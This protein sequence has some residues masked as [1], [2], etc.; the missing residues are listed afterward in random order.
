MMGYFYGCGYVMY[1]N[2]SVSQAIYH[3]AAIDTFDFSRNVI[4][5]ILLPFSLSVGFILFTIKKPLLW[6]CHYC[7]DEKIKYWQKHGFFLSFITSSVAAL[8]G[9][10][11]VAFLPDEPVSVTFKNAHDAYMK[12]FN[13][14]PYDTII[15]DNFVDPKQIHFKQKKPR[16]LI[17]IFAESFERTFTD[18]SLFGE[19]LL[20]ELSN[21]GGTSV[22]GYKPLEEIAWTQVSIIATLCG[23]TSKEYFP[24]R[25]LSKNIACISDITRKFGYNNYY[26]Q[27]T[28]LKFLSTRTFFEDHNFQEIVGI[29]E[30]PKIKEKLSDLQF[31]R[32]NLQIR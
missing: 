8:L 4:L 20:P 30:L 32:K 22:I 23:I 12:I 27:G 17:I 7:S 5:T 21:L 18:A 25:T 2:F 10:F 6:L 29:D 13:P 16:N 24:P 1:N 11:I 15:D 26:L 31:T 14:A 3:L 28:T 9:V 19:N